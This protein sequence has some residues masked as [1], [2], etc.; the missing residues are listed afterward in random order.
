MSPQCFKIV[1][2]MPSNPMDLQGFSLSMIL[3]TPYGVMKR[4]SKTSLPSASSSV[5]LS[6]KKLS[7]EKLS[8]YNFTYI[9]EMPVQFV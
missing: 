7:S 2:P 6:D 4:I 1:G 3:R 8:F 9:Y 5:S